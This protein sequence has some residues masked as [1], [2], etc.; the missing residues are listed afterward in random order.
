MK[1][2]HFT[3]R[4]KKSPC[5]R[6]MPSLCRHAV[7]AGP[8]GIKKPIL[9]GPPILPIYRPYGSQGFTLRY[10]YTVPT[11]LGNK[12]PPT[13][14]GHTPILPTCRPYGTG[15]TGMPS[16]LLTPQGCHIGRHSNPPS[17]PSSKPHRGDISVTTGVNPATHP[18]NP[19]FGGHTPIL[20][21]Y[22]P[23]GSQ[24]FTLRYRYIVPTGLGK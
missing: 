17:P 8:R 23:C 22:R 14:G 4:L 24:G 3:P 1:H 2:T 15:E 20:P 11:G 5:F 12:K 18:Q 21:I 13:C 7:P 10:R 9:G 19:Y 6:G 16:S